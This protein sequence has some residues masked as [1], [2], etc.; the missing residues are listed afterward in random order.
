IVALAVGGWIYWERAEHPSPSENLSSPPPVA[1][2]AP[3]LEPQSPAVLAWQLE[4]GKPI[5]LEMKTEG[6]KSTTTQG[7]TSSEEWKQ[8]F[9]FRW[10]PERQSDGSWLLHMTLQGCTVDLRSGIHALHFDTTRRND[11]PLSETL[12]GAEF[13]VILDADLK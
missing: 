3:H 8:T 5:F 6:S 9:Y 1:E 13:H 12:V 2:T 10:L 7:K 11:H 4:T